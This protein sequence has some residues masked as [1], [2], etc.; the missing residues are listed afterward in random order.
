MELAR[1]SA[2]A[3]AATIESDPSTLAR[4][5]WHGHKLDEAR[6]SGDIAIEGD[7]QSVTRFLALFPLPG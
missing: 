4:V 3:P 7:S 1:G 5:L 6:R 2:E